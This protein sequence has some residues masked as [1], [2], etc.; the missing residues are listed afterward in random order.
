MF[1]YQFKLCVHFPTVATKLSLGQKLPAWIVFIIYWVPERQVI[2]KYLMITKAT[3][4]EKDR[5]Y[6]ASPVSLRHQDE[7]AQRAP[8]WESS[9][10]R[11][12]FSGSSSWVVLS[13]WTTL[14]PQLRHRAGHPGSV[15]QLHR[16]LSSLCSALSSAHCLCAVLLV[17][18]MS[19]WTQ[20]DWESARWRFSLPWVWTAGVVSE[21]WVSVALPWGDSDG[22]L[23]Q[24]S[25]ACLHSSSEWRC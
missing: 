20:P 9:W 13:W 15:D 25:R 21:M 6:S 7:E 10:F 5:R 16:H 11:G 22:A 12:M 3:F 14:S 18:F 1:V 17:T 23:A 8:G 4:N 2:S 19:L 24:P